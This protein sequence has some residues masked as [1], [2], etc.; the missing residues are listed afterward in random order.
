MKEYGEKYPGYYFEENACY[1]TSKHI[2]KIKEIGPCDIHR[3]SFLK[4]ILLKINN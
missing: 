3:K 4:N 2:E 1:G